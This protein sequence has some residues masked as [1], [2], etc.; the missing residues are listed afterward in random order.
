VGCPGYKTSLDISSG[1]S[2]H[3]EDPPQTIPS[4]FQSKYTCWLYAT[5]V[6]SRLIREVPD[7]VHTSLPFFYRGTSKGSIRQYHTVTLGA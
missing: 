2:S 6:N 1:P 4:P 5:S 7:C 3:S